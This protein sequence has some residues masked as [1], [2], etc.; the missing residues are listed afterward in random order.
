MKIDAEI[1][2]RVDL[3]DLTK[4]EV[5]QIRE[6]LRD[7]KTKTDT[8]FSELINKYEAERAQPAVIVQGRKV[9]GLKRIDDVRRHLRRLDQVFGKRMLQDLTYDDLLQRKLALCKKGYAISTVHREL[10]VARSLFRFAE[11]RGLMNINPFNAGLPLISKGS[12]VRRERILSRQEEAQLLAA[13]DGEV[14]RSHLKPFLVCALDTAARRGELFELRWKD[15]FLEEGYIRLLAENTKTQQ[16]RLATLTPRL[17]AELLELRKRRRADGEGGADDLVFGLTHSIK[18]SFS[19]VCEKAGIEDLHL[20]DLRHT[21][22]TRMIAA[23]IPTSEVMK[24]SGHS[25][26]VT[27]QRYLN[28]SPK[29]ISKISE[30]FARYLDEADPLPTPQK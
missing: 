30:M 7:R 2:N 4:E 26:M 9:S 8:T 29:R 28:P 1:P 11:R 18:R 24:I 19:T 12:E 14:R 6:H 21:A 3:S 10:E 5:A 22:I 17:M 13:C 16:S 20:H 23:G 25:Q 27:F 15:V